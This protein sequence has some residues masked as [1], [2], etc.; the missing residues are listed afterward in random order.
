LLF[1]RCPGQSDDVREP[2]LGLGSP[3]GLHPH[4]ARVRDFLGGDLD[5][6]RQAAVRLSLDG[7]RDHG[8]LRSLFPGLAAPLSMIIAVPTG[9]KVFNWLFTMYGG[10]V[11]F[12]VPV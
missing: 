3:G 5:L 2:L 10:R 1:A 4:L 8:D 6:L 7:R 12:T 9:V 11:R